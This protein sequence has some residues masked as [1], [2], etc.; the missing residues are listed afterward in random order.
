MGAQTETIGSGT[1]IRIEGRTV[2]PKIKVASL[3]KTGYMDRF[4]NN[5]LSKTDRALVRVAIEEINVEAIL[6]KVNEALDLMES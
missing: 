6:I 1:V 2:A 4:V 5:A 3:Y